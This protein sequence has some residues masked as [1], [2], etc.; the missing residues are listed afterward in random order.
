VVRRGR[1]GLRDRWL[2]AIFNHDGI[3]DSCRVLMVYLARHMS[4]RGVVSVPQQTISRALGIQ[5]R[6]VASRIAEARAAGVLDKLGGGYHGRTAEYVAVMPA[7]KRAA[8]RHPSPQRVTQN[9]TLPGDRKTSP[10]PPA[11]SALKGAAERHPNAR[12]TTERREPDDH[13]S[14]HGDA[15]PGAQPQQRSDESDTRDSALAAV[16]D[17]ERTA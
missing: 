10:F 3:G 9:R 2:D 8:Q 7:K 14:N 12:V 11:G 5:P 6:R 17:H 4:D 15:L 16:F 1:A 13:A